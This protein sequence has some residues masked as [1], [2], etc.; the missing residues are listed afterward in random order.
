MNEALPTL[1]MRLPIHCA[2][3]SFC[4]KMELPPAVP[5]LGHG[6]TQSEGDC[7]CNDCDLRKEQ[8]A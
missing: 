5:L 2:T 6:A 8:S 1:G 7:P 3:Q 4:R